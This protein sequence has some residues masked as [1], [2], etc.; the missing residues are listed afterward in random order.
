MSALED[1]VRA[2]MCAG[3]ACLAEK[4]AKGE[5]LLDAPLMDSLGSF[6]AEFLEIRPSL[7]DDLRREWG[8]Q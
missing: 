4:A 2:A 6:P 8:V 5:I 7:A 1:L 3:F